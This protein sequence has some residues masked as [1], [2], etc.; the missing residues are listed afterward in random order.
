MKPNDSSAMRSAL[1]RRAF[2][3]RVGATAASVALADAFATA[4]AADAGKPPPKPENV[5]TPDAALDRLMQGNVRYVDGVAKR[6]D[7]KAE[8]EALAG[9]QNPF[10]AI[11]S[12]ADSRIAPEYAFD[13]ARGD[14]FVVRLAG[15]FANADAIASLEY[16]V[17]ILG[18]PLIMVLGHGS[19]GAVEATIKSV[20]GGP[21]L[22]GHLPSLVK[23]ITPAVEAVRGK[24]GDR[25]A[26]AIEENVVLNVK[27]LNGATPILSQAVG[28]KKLRV[29]GG[30]Y[31]LATGKVRMI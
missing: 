25:L 24:P 19:C 10:A 9:G 1:A 30:V 31:D 8:R 3:I 17:A 16:A 27:T 21:P 6:H 13:A 11:L 7:F 18:V 29:V 14:L 22:P 15:N 4:N 26:N 2:L 12:C 20:D 5:L 28:N 23:A